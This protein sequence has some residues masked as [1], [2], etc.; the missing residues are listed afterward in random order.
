MREGLYRFEFL[1]LNVSAIKQ[2]GMPI[3]SLNQCEVMMKIQD[4]DS[5]MR[6]FFVDFSNRTTNELYKDKNVNRGSV[7]VLPIF[8]ERII[9][10]EYKIYYNLFQESCVLQAIYL[11]NS[12]VWRR[13]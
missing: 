5:V 1:V 7:T 11:N 6:E 9:F 10:V 3:R 4:I 12:R 2:K 8:D 13:R